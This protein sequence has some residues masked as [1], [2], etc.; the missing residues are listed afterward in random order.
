MTAAEWERTRLQAKRMS[1]PSRHHRGG[2]HP[3]R[4]PSQWGRGES[5]SRVLR[6]S[7]VCA[8]VYVGMGVRACVRARA[9]VRVYVC[10]HACVSGSTPYLG[11]ICFSSQQGRLLFKAR[12]VIH[13]QPHP[14]R[15]AGFCLTP[16]VLA[17]LVPTSVLYVVLSVAPGTHGRSPSVYPLPKA[18]FSPTS[19]WI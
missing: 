12:G 15:V 8:G 5:G 2:W 9:C 4:L 6:P 7:S 14:L 17:T 18:K 13:P 19:I 10:T 16:P 3:D 1:A 11:H